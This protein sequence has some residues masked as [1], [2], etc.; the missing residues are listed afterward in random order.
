MIFDVAMLDTN[1]E[2]I[3]LYSAMG[4]RPAVIVVYRGA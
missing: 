2:S 4:G 1:E 3:S